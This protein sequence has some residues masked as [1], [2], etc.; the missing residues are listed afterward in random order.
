MPA[1]VSATLRHTNQPARASG[2][3]WISVSAILR[4]AVLIV[5]CPPRGMASR[6]FTVRFR[7][8]CSI[9]VIHRFNRTVGHP[10]LSAVARPDDTVALPVF[11]RARLRE[12]YGLLHGQATGFTTHDGFLG[13]AFPKP[14][15]HFLSRV[16]G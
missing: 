2:L 15:R 9:Q 16:T 7:R 3:R 1:P 5:N 14:G 12:T 6:A 13:Q 11:D 10:P 8:I 4:A